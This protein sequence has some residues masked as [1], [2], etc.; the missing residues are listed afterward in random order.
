MYITLKDKSVLIVEDDVNCLQSTGKLFQNFV[1]HVYYAHDISSAL[2]IFES[3]TIDC[4][5]CDILLGKEDGLKLIQII[6]EYNENIPI[7]V[8]SGYINED[9]LLRAIPLNL[10]GYLHKPIHYSQFMEALS[11][12]SQK[13]GKSR[14]NL[15]YVKNNYYYNID[16]KIIK[17]EG[18]VYK[19]HHREILFIEMAIKNRNHIITKS[20]FYEFVWQFQ[21]MTDS[22]L[23][24][25]ILR[26]RRRFGKDFLEAVN[27]IGYRF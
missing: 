12:C 27:N 20:M 23:K 9:I 10:S 26:I 14:K 3:T 24:N 16:L 22:A 4:M 25:F 5:I 19:L 8:I 7:I 2:K 13:M 6:R 15:I 11:I 18:R 21:E 1:K 17:K